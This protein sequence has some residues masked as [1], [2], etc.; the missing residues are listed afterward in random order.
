MEAF[1]T[2]AL[3]YRGNQ[4]SQRYQCSFH[5]CIP[6][7]SAHPA[8]PG[9]MV[10]CWVLCSHIIS[11]FQKYPSPDVFLDILPRPFYQTYFIFCGLSLH[12]SFSE[13]SWQGIGTASRWPC[14][15]TKLIHG[16]SS[17]II[18]SSIIQPDILSPA[19]QSKTCN[20]H[21]RILAYVLLVAA[22]SYQLD[23]VIL[24][25]TQLFPPREGSALPHSGYT[26]N[27]S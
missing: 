17:Y 3:V 19:P 18:K 14:L 5:Q 9:K 16:R 1:P 6:Y 10:R 12:L 13:P 24:W 25:M 22:S 20:I 26:K 11:S 23:L 8:F 21:S 7:C 15:A 2:S 27:S 4:A